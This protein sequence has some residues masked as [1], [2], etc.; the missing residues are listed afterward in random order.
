MNA[1]IIAVGSELLTP[2][3]LDTNSL[4][5]TEELNA[6]GIEVLRKCVVGDDRERLSE[7]VSAALAR[8]DL[9]ILTGG[10]GPTEDDVTREA[11]AGALG[12]EL[13]LHQ[14]ALERIQD[15]FRRFGR[16]MA[17]NNRRQ[18]YVVDG[19]EL[20]PNERGTAPGQWIDVNGRVVMLLPGPPHE[21][22]SIFRQQCLPRLQRAVPPSVIRTRFLRVAGMTE[23]ELD[24][25]IAPVY[26]R[27]QNPATTILAAA[28]EIQVHLR[29]RCGTTEEAECLLEEVCRQIT[30]LLGDRVYTST[31]EALEQCIG[32]LLL[33]RGATVSAAESCTG[34]LL[35]E[36][37]TGVA[38]SS[39]YFAGGF[40]TYSDELKERLLGIS[41]EL[42]RSE[43]AV[44]EPAAREMALG[45]RRALGTTY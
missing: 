31:G 22:E 7:A 37:I 24:Q 26:T 32:R 3:R 29:A 35:A 8:A 45:C 5:L 17:E 14:P 44:S 9:V 40:I 11:V 20:L 4:H 15:R 18:A 10:L 34:G 21:L 25:L 16:R 6:L 27:Y 38:G 36:R 43:G 30:P 13:V 2:H 19:A 41:A 39:N 12:R 23:S 42:L 1:E 28:G 33:E